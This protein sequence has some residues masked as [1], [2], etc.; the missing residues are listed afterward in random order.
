MDPLD[1]NPPRHLRAVPLII[2]VALFMENLNSSVLATALPDIARDL[3][4]DPIHLKLVLTTYLLALAVFIP[5]SGWMADRFGAR[6]VFRA[7]I[8]VFAVGSIACGASQNLLELVLARVL[9]G[10]GGSMMVPV[11][12]LILLKT[13]PRSELVRAMAW[14]TVPAL[15][16]PMM[17]PVVG[18]WITTFWHWRWIF[19]INIP[20]ALVG[21]VLS[22]IFIPDVREE[23]SRGFDFRGFLLM[24]PGLSGFLTG[25]TLAGLGLADAWL[26]GVLVVGG[27]A[28]CVA[29]AFHA[30]RV[31]N[32]LVDLRLMQLATYRVAMTAGTI[33]RIGSGA[34][35]FLL[36]LMLQLGF[37]YSAF[38]SG[39]LT[40]VTAL[41]A[42]TM[43]F[44][45]E[46]ILR[47]FGFGRVLVV[48]GAIAAV[49]LLVPGFFRPEMSWLAM[50]PVLYAGGLS[51]S[52]QFTSINAIAYADVSAR[53]MSS[54]TSLTSVLQQLAGAIG[55]TVAAMSLEVVGWARGISPTA[56]P[57]YL[58]TFGVLAVL[59]LIAVAMFTRLPR[60]AGHGLVRAART[61]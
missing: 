17:G 21:L 58:P 49:F 7:A 3:A 34:T 51:R 61:V 35:P 40:F 59:A 22:T 42:I 24:G 55:I 14:L 43:K 56:L 52:L 45:A 12:R 41:G 46:P 27:L 36:P 15:I 32:P 25:V 16:G 10:M 23:G 26:I 60:G 57:N 54:A 2:A 13:T 53:Q 31:D 29:Y 28:L 19:W 50:A 38:A 33:F 9:Q 8:L 48:N 47:R 4:T 44:L 18:G 6:R 39:T 1:S 37:G 20:I 11:G 5:A 30:L